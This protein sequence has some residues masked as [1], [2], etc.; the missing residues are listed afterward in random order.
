M[1][2][3]NYRRNGKKYSSCGPSKG[4]LAPKVG[5]LPGSE[6]TTG[7]KPLSSRE[8]HALKRGKKGK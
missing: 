8:R 7:P 2:E 4:R 1:S 6:R 5:Q 3:V